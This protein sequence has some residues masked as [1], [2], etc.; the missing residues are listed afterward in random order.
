MR[1]MKY[2]FSYRGISIPYTLERK[3]VK[4]INLRIRGG[5]VIVS[6]AGFVPRVVIE[7]F[8]LSRAEMILRA[9]ER[10]A[11]CEERRWVGGERLFYLLL[12]AA[13]P[14]RRSGCARCAPAGATAA[15]GGLS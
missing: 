2:S 12:P 8:L 15:P 1:G 11:L 7:R 13:C 9:V 4:N 6:A 5:E 3:R 14:G 10:T